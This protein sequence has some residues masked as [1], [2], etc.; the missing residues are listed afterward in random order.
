MTVGYGEANR[1]SGRTMPW[2]LPGSLLLLKSLP[3]EQ[4]PN[5]CSFLTM[6]GPRSEVI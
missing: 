4:Y 1:E 2:P 6:I 5:G 3:D